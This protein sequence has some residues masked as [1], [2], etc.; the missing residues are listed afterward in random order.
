MKE[1]DPMKKI[2]AIVLTLVLCAGLTA[3]GGKKSD[4]TTIKVGAS[5]A[6]HA[7]LLELCVEPLAAK[8]ITLEI[9]TFEDYVLPNTATEDG[10]I[11]ANFFQHT[12]YLTSFNESNG[13]HLV[14]I[15]AV[16]YEPL[17]IYPGTAASFDEVKANGGKIA[18][19]NDASNEARA[20]LLLEANGII[21]LDPNAGIN[22]TKQDIV[23]NPYNVEIVEIEAAQLTAHLPDVALAVINGNYAI[24]AGLSV[25][26]DAIAIEEASSTAAQTYANILVVK[27]GNE[28][29]EAILALLAE[30]QGETVKSYIAA[31]YDGAV[32][33]AV[34]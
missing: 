32:V 14:S 29:N 12:P 15:G 17:G 23:D 9:V 26:N 10:S 11:D 13:T 34:G 8:G 21:T 19:P 28:N 31:T 27:E 18:V 24:A 22:A 3:C 4:G 20:L 1:K 33:S 2:L 6:P 25:A 16:H 5:P 7:E 30:L